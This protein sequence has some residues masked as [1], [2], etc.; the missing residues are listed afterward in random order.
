M[1][2]NLGEAV[3]FAPGDWLRFGAA[4]LGRLRYFRK[5]CV[6]S[7]E[8]MLLRVAAQQGVR[9]AA[10]AKGAPALPA[11][12]P[13]RADGQQAQ[14]DGDAEMADGEASHGVQSSAD[15]GGSSPLLCYYLRQELRRVVDEEWV[16]RAKLWSQGGCHART[17]CSR[18]R[19][20]HTRW[21]PCRLKRSACGCARLTCSNSHSL[22]VP[23]LWT[24][25]PGLSS[26]PLIL[27]QMP[28]HSQRLV[29]HCRPAALAAHPFGCGL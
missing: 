12:A 21:A 18:C 10:A 4:A 5:P 6:V 13:P 9:A 7:Q 27:P 15:E 14:Q 20:P 16:L 11:P 1:G 2:V 25:Q 23:I 8:E 19:L 24:P 26:C 22:L 29:C 17:R 3:N 28:P